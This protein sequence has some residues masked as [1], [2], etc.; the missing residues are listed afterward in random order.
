M[1]SS[2]AAPQANSS[3]AVP[4]RESYGLDR[5]ALAGDE[6]AYLNLKPEEFHSFVLTNRL[7]LLA[8]AAD[9]PPCTLTST[10]TDDLPTLSH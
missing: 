9:T 3:D 10:R 4:Q 5:I 7:A 8:L 1:R 6:L 2:T